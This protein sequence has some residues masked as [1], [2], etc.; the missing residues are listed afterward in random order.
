MKKKLIQILMLLVATV[1]VG[2]FVSCKD[3]NEDLYN[4]LRTQYIKDNA[5]LQEAYNA[6]IAKLQEQLD[7][8]QQALDAIRTCECDEDGMQ[9]T[10][11]GLNQQIENINRE[12]ETLTN[13]LSNAATK[14][15]VAAVN[16]LVDNLRQ[17]VESINGT[18][19]TFI[20]A[21]NP[22]LATVNT[23]DTQISGLEQAVQELRTALAEIE[24]CK[25][26]HEKFE[27][28]LERLATLE[29]RM[30][31]AE[32]LVDQALGLATTADRNAAL[33][34]QAADAATNAASQATQAAQNAVTT[35]ELAQQAATNAG[36]TADAAQRLA[37]QASSNANT[38]LQTANEANSLANAVQT[39]AQQAMDK[40]TQAYNKASTNET[41]IA[42]LT[43][44]ARIIENL[45]NRHQEAIEKNAQDITDLSG[46][47]DKNISD[48][49]QNA[50]DIAT[51]AQNIQTNANNIQQ[52]TSDI[53]NIN[54]QL[55]TMSEATQRAMDRANEAYAYAQANHELFHKLDSTLT[56]IK[57]L[58]EEKFSN[59]DNTISN[60]TSKLNELE[61]KVNSNTSK[62]TGL[63]TAVNGLTET[64]R[65]LVNKVD[66][67]VGVVSNL[68]SELATLKAQ[69]EG[70][71]DQARLIAQEEIATAKADILAQIAAEYAKLS[72][73]PDFDQFA[74]KEQL[75]DS[76]RS[77]T[78]RVLTE[79]GKDRERI[80]ANETAIWYINEALRYL[81]AKFDNYYT[82]TE[83][84]A[85]LGQT[86]S[87]LTL[88]LT[89]TMNE[90]INELRDEINSTLTDKISQ[91]LDD[92]NYITEDDVEPIVNSI[93]AG[94][95][96][97]DIQTLVELVTKVKTLE[98]TTV[99][100]DTF[101]AARDSVWAQVNANTTDIGTI[102]TELE[103]M[104]AS[105]ETLQE[106]VDTLKDHM[107]KAEQRLDKV[108]KAIEDLVK[109][110]EAIQEA[111]A[112][113]VTN[114]IIQGTY[115]PMFGSFS[116]P[117]NIQSNVLVAYYGVPAKDVEFPTSEGMNYVRP[118]ERLT[119]KDMAMINGVEIF[120]APANLP[121]LN[122]DYKA[123][124]VYMTINPNTAD[125]EGLKLSIVNTLDEESL[126]KLSPI[127]KCEEKLQFGYS[128]ANNG[129]YVADATVTPQTVMEGD[130]GLALTRDDITRLYHAVHE[131]I[132]KLAENFN[133][134]GRQTDLAEL[135][136]SIYQV[137]RNMRVDRNGLKCTYTT[138]EADGTEKEHS[139]YSEYNLAATF[140]KPLNLAWGKDFDPYV[141]MP[142][143]EVF[144]DLL[145]RFAATLKSHVDVLYDNA[146][147]IG[148]IQNLIQNLKIDEITY[149][150]E[151]SNLIRYFKVRASN[152]TLNGVDYRLMVPA[153]GSFDVKFDKKLKA[154]GSQ[155]AVPASV[156]FD[157]DAVNV[158]KATLV[159][160]GDIYG[161]LKT[162][163]I[164]PAAGGDGVVSAYAS[165]D[166]DAS[167]L[168]A[169]FVD[170]MIMLR[171]DGELYPVASYMGGS[172]AITSDCMNSIVLSDVVG[173]G[174]S[175]NLP[176]AVEISNDLLNLLERQGT[177]INNVVAE[178]NAML[179]NINNYHG[180]INGW[181]DSGIDEFLRKYLDQINADV[182]FFFN[183]INRRFGPFLVASDKNGFKRLG[184]KEVPVAMEADNL[185]FYP[186]TKTM[187][188]IVPLARKHVAV[189]NVFKGSASAQDG[190]SDCKAK[191]QAA[192]TGDLN[193]VLDGTV[194]KIDVTGLQKGY[195][196]EVAYSI[197]DFDG[198][199]STM[200][201]YITLK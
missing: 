27:D 11:N 60:M 142:G 14:D 66:S 143:Y 29:Q 10:I 194:R 21:A 138:T 59:L 13:G 99:S 177:T 74:T 173:T 117:A 1:S 54:T 24:E 196:Y 79:I 123:G 114:I 93:I 189:T 63:E 64:N 34:Q 104:Q 94:A 132:V 193:T 103:T 161:D 118:E 185:A 5:S 122:E 110:V 86:K 68:E 69:A 188:L 6:Q 106:D 107:T 50:Q 121:L 171:K 101:N 78:E 162:K 32:S 127:R 92:N 23:H 55:T 40:A 151:A 139:V 73:L 37:E 176:I 128:R 175:L 141:T 192:N 43:E 144:D 56:V 88:E 154:G 168:R 15:E 41:N 164:V 108:E 155:V 119:D 53:R 44:N 65:Y 182:V 199:I 96:V 195:V 71:K 98:S 112:K 137:I 156:A 100:I 97:E 17:Q 169:D 174:G 147:N 186:T 134:P 51:N 52:L 120:E 125:L 149:I 184:T 3:T 145:N 47:V 42:T 82:K 57:T 115:N 30:A 25:C 160:Y 166:L 181:I 102:K 124:K 158:T 150:G 136:T 18:L 180:I 19:N 165:L 153:A 46:K 190:D 109:D 33:A 84:D 126:I 20:A 35:A 31:T 85:L 113:Q 80:S 83:I 62:I 105:I 22:I 28:M 49:A 191:L 26:D 7:K 12:I 198:N 9:N 39:L 183:S 172:F 58:Y 87:D 70:F 167:Y 178:L 200:K 77:I 91:Y 67:L 81:S 45:V 133:T 48:I 75:K 130:N 152:I 201:G 90:K 148:N 163:I 38:A 140:L 146:I 2:S 36:L 4:E 111:L 61:G 157:S 129:F 116:I 8:Y 16:T 179:N 197:L 72:D 131:Q 170:E 95:G 135:A 89:N 187:E 76:L 159:V